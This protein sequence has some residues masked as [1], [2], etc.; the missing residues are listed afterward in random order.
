MRVKGR[1]PKVCLACLE[2]PPDRGGV[3]RSAGRIAKY[4][5]EE[6][7]DV[8]VFTP[9]R[10]EPQG[11][12][13]EPFL[14]DGA[15]VYRVAS[16][17]SLSTEGITGAIQ[18]ADDA[19]SFDIFHGVYLPM[20]YPC[21]L[22]DPDGLRPLIAS[23]QGSD[24]VEWGVNPVYR[25]FMTAVLKRASWVTS[26]NTDYLRTAADLADISG[27]SSFI[28]NGVDSAAFPRWRPTE[29]N[30]GVVGT[31]TVFRDVKNIPLLIQSYAGVDARVRKRLLLVGDFPEGDENERFKVREAIRRHKVGREVRVTGYVGMPQISE[32]LLAMRV[33]VLCSKH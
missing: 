31:V 1:S 23:I 24:A 14:Q 6:G 19:V 16:G 12:P 10:G 26:V 13:P 18:A 8:H 30:R 3:A 28:P 15:K 32:N 11:L 5:V 2:Y 4:L 22:T 7:F 20:A 25:E 29:A 33:F 9:K 27:R 21:M 17:L